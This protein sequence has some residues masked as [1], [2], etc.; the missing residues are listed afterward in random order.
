MAVSRGN[1]EYEIPA[2]D[3]MKEVLR[4]RAFLHALKGVVMLVNQDPMGV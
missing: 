1:C 2:G 4:L 3:L